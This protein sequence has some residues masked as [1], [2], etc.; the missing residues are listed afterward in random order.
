[1]TLE[2]WEIGLLNLTRTELRL[3]GSDPEDRD[4]TYWQEVEMRR[5]L[6]GLA[7]RGLVE[8][9]VD[10]YRVSPALYPLLPALRELEKATRALEPPSEYSDW[11]LHC[12]IHSC[13]FRKR[14]P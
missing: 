7:S 2:D 1:M 12:N 6:P 13:T 5:A 4:Y 11:Q 8:I 14:D 3:L 10:G 9:T